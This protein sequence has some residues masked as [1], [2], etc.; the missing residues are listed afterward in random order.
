MTSRRFVGTRQGRL[1]NR[2][3]VVVGPVGE[4]WT[5]VSG[6]RTPQTD[7]NLTPLL[8][9]PNSVRPVPS[10][11][12]RTAQWG[13]GRPPTA[14][15]VLVEASVHGRRPPAPGLQPLEPRRPPAVGVIGPCRSGRMSCAG[16]LEGLP[17]VLDSRRGKGKGQGG[18]VRTVVSERL[19]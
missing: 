11:V 2:T 6:S 19:G 9:R 18:G 17:L 4:P 16:R 7:P 14:V 10:P 15:T 12:G 8:P 3:P 13:R 5:P 1:G